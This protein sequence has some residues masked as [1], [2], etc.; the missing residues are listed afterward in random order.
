MRQKAQRMTFGNIQEDVFQEHMGVTLGQMKHGGHGGRIRAARVDDK[1][2][3]RMSQKLQRQVQRHT[4]GSGTSTVASSTA[5]GRRTNAA[6]VSG[7]AS[8]VTFTPVQVQLC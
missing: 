1:S 5:G 7:T 6:T 8:T 3:A 4:P 2:R